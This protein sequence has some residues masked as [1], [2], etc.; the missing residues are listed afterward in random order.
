MVGNTSAARQVFTGNL[1]EKYNLQEIRSE[2]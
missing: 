2:M 1:V